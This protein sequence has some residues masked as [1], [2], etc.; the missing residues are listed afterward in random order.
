MPSTRAGW[1]FFLLASMTA[2]VEHP[3]GS[4]MN[5]LHG[6]QKLWTRKLGGRLLRGAAQLSRGDIRCDNLTM[7]SGGTTLFFFFPPHHLP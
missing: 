5:R 3:N 6:R 2:V 7:T 4:N 1:S